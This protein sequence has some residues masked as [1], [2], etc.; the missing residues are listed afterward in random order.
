MSDEL[1]GVSKEGMR[2]VYRMVCFMAWCDEELDDAEREVL[3][4]L[5]GELGLSEVEAATLETEGREVDGLELGEDEAELKVLVDSLIDVAVADGKLVLEEQARLHR[6]AKMI[7][8]PDLVGRMAARI[9]ERGTD[10]EIARW[11]TPGT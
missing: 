9:R 7:K 8:V 11:E 1:A 3:D 5:R 6:L 2:R 10:L 4:R